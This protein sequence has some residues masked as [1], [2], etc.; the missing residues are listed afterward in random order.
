[1]VPAGDERRSEDCERLPEDR[2]FARLKGLRDR[3]TGLTQA[4]TP[5]RPLPCRAMQDYRPQEGTSLKKREPAQSRGFRCCSM[6]TNLVV[7]LASQESASWNTLLITL[8]M[9]DSLRQS[10]MAT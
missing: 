2:W 10:F 5:D 8:K 1:M 6:L 3:S 4:A 9:L 7:L